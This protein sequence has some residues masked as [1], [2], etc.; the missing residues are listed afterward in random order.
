MKTKMTDT[1][2]T[3]NTTTSRQKKNDVEEGKEEVDAPTFYPV[4]S[5]S[6]KKKKNTIETSS[7]MVGKVP[8]SGLER[9]GAPSGEK[10]DTEER[11]RGEK[12]EKNADFVDVEK[13]G[14]WGV[15]S[16]TEVIVV[17]VLVV[18]IVVAVIITLVL[19]LG[20]DSDESNEDVAKPS[21]MLHPESQMDLIRSALA[22]YEITASV[23]DDFTSINPYRMAAAWIVEK[24][25]IN[26]E[27][28]IIPRFALAVLYYATGGQEWI[29]SDGWLSN[30]TICDGWYGIHCNDNGDLVE[31]DLHDNNLSG[32]L[33]SALVFLPS[34]Q[35]LW[36]SNNH[37]KGHLAEGLFPNMTSLEFFYVQNNDLSGT[38]PDTFLLN[39][40]KLR[41]LF[42]S[43]SFTTV[44]LQSFSNP[45]VLTPQAPFSFKVMI[46]RGTFRKSTA[47]LAKP[48]S[49]PFSPLE[50]TART[51]LVPTSSV[52]TPSSTVSI[53]SRTTTETTPRAN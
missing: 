47:R 32:E 41:K 6:K 2:K 33:P 26:A 49:I 39:N 48:V 13:T 52:V 37:L 53:R 10:C 12:R 21:A 45:S 31:I 9:N 40:G 7:S 4:K 27:V 15:V 14:R 3:S 42:H 5:D 30:S 19:V 17:S 44:L 34:L 18:L 11:P 29:N 25:P 28:D 16:K 50:S 22:E 20:G 1:P 35:A 36:L 46:S 24:D 38:I 51:M 8:T 23:W 43:G